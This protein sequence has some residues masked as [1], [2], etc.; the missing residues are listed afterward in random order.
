MGNLNCKE[1]FGRD[2]SFKNEMLLAKISN[3]NQFD[4]NISRNRRDDQ[5]K[6]LKLKEIEN[7]INNERNINGIPPKLFESKKQKKVSYNTLRKEE[8]DNNNLLKTELNKIREI[9]VDKSNSDDLSKIIESQKEKIIAQ[10][11][12]IEE[13]KYKQNLLE[14]W[15][16]QLEQTQTKIREQQSLLNLQGIE[17]NKTYMIP[18]ITQ[19]D[20]DIENNEIIKTSPTDM[21][22]YK[23]KL[24]PSK[25]TPKLQIGVR[26]I[27]NDYNF[28]NLDKF[29]RTL[30]TKSNFNN[31]RIYQNDE[32]QIEENDNYERVDDYDE[33]DDDKINQQRQSQRF[34]IETYEPIE[35]GNKN[36]NDEII[37]DY[38]INENL[39]LEPRDSTKLNQKKGSIPKSNYNKKNTKKIYDK[40]NKRDKG[41]RDSGNSGIKI[42]FRGTFENKNMN[43]INIGPRDS[44]RK[45]D[46]EFNYNMD[47][48]EIPYI[49]DNNDVIGKNKIKNNNDDDEVKEV[50]IEQQEQFNNEQK[51]MNIFKNN[52]NIYIPNDYFFNQQQESPK[53]NSRYNESMNSSM[54]NEENIEM[55]TEIGKYRNAETYG[56][57][58]NEADDINVVISADHINYNRDNQGQEQINKELDN[59]YYI[60]NINDVEVI[61]NNNTGNPLIYDDNKINMNFFNNKNEYYQ[62]QSSNN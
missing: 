51:N 10:E 19:N 47:N 36:E 18:Y 62:D 60:N 21:T 43:N 14:K 26:N 1:C 57:Y 27:K 41:P 4:Q 58:L 8:T 39:F 20:E 6:V 50:L 30:E 38:K 23:K 12:I 40:M 13:Y 31:E 7:H 48:I 11:K 42:N 34:K 2:S 15:Q 22:G 49:I 25:S 29:E 9:N 53:F 5:L 17:N 32:G 37:K 35:V 54:Q 33:E 55:K 52:N 24:M 16:E 59:E 56:P 3:N 46:N 45:N 61:D 44:K 28:L